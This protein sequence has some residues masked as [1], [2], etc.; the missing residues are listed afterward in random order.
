MIHPDIGAHLDALRGILFDHK[1]KEAYVFGSAV[2]GSFTKDSD[3]DLL[4]E[5]EPGVGE[6]EYAD[7]WWDLGDRLEELVERKVDLVT[8]SSIRNKYL[9]MELESTR[10]VIL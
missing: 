5:F 3:L 1:V 4:I 8:L 6:L 2:K 7:L 10:E 9:R